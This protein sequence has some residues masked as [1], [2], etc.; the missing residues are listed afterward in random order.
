MQSAVLTTAIQYVR[1][2]YAA[3]LPRRLKVGSRSLHFEIAKHSSFLT[4]TMIRA[5]SPST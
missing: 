5:T 2:L 3:T 1:L 4:A